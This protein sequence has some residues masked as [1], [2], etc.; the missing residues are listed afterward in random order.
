MKYTMIN[1]KK[2]D[3]CFYASIN[4]KRRAWFSSSQFNCCYGRYDR[5][6]HYD[7]KTYTYY[8]GCLNIEQIR[9]IDVLKNC[10][11]KRRKGNWWTIK[12]LKEKCKMNKIKGYSKFKK[13]EEFIQALMKI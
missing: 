9:K 10:D 5:Y 8:N 12:E 1:Y 4:N 11:D 6:K 7:G 3:G 2:S 13:K